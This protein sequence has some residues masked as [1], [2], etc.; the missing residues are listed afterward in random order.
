MSQNLGDPQINGNSSFRPCSVLNLNS[1][2]SLVFSNCSAV[3]YQVCPASPP[4]SVLLAGPLAT[5]G[6]PLAS[7][8][9]A[10]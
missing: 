4:G 6:L 5:K 1:D 8:S 2:L 9:P 3:F 10:R 7:L